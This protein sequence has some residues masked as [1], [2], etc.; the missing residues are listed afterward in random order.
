MEVLNY[1]IAVAFIIWILTLIV[2]LVYA[3]R[4]E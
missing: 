3:S 1:K 4:E 2:S